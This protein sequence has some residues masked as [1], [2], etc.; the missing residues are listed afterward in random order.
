LAKDPAQKANKLAGNILY[1]VEPAGPLEPEKSAGNEA[2]EVKRSRRFSNMIHSL[3]PTYAEIVALVRAHHRLVVCTVVR[4]QG[5]V[6]RGV[7]ARFVVLPD[8][9]ARGTVGGGLFESRVVQDALAALAARESGT[10]AYDF[11]PKGTSAEAFGAVCGGKAEIYFDVVTPPDDLLIVGGGHCGRALARAAALL[12]SFAVT[13]VDDRPEFARREDLPE[14]VT[15]ARVAP[16]FG[17]LAGYLHANAY[18]A[19]VSQGYLTDLA[20]LRQ[21]LAAAGPPAY[22]GMMGSRRK[23]RTVRE[24]LLAEG[25]S[26]EALDSVQAPIGLEIG[27]ET[28]AEI[29]ISI[30]AQILDLRAKRARSRAT[31][32]DSE[33]EN[34]VDRSPSI[35]Y[36]DLSPEQ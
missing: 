7:G 30:L 25:V 12:G 34:P 31:A 13:L 1:H 4:T 32:V 11:R 27:S 14:A 15:V 35:V 24:A 33:S 3:E 26:K 9:A 2:P 23:V 18:V 29:A 19:L 17:D 21:A 16:D 10:R 22:I 20:A 5:S 28:P 36:D 6:P 8:G